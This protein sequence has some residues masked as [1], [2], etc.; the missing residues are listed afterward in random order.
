MFWEK[1]TDNVDMKGSDYIVITVSTWHFLCFVW[2]QKT[3]KAIRKVKD[4]E[5]IFD[6]Y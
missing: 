1:Q 6:L 2:T 4:G 5:E 3:V